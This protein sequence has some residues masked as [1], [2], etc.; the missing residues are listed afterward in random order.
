MRPTV[1]SLSALMAIAALPSSGRAQVFHGV[2]LDRELNKPVLVAAVTLVDFSNRVRAASITDSAG[3]YEITAPG[4]GRYKVRV[5]PRGYHTMYTGEYIVDVSDTIEVNVV[6]SASPDPIQST[7]IRRRTLAVG[8]VPPRNEVDEKL[9]QQCD[10]TW[11]VEVYNCFHQPINVFYSSEGET[12]SFGEVAARQYAV[13]WAATPTT[14]TPTVSV[15]PR[16]SVTNFRDR[17]KGLITVR[18]YCDPR[19]RQPGPG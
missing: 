1:L 14:T 6:V 7:T 16:E 5:D 11:A 10:G 19:V 12:L 2:V 4:P 3:R 17:S 15:R 9:P 18:L 8:C 13:L